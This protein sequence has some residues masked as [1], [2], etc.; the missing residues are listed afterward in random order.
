MEKPV[1]LKGWMP[2]MNA[3]WRHIGK[4]ITKSLMLKRVFFPLRSPSLKMENLPDRPKSA[5]KDRESRAVIEAGFI[6]FTNRLLRV[7]I[8]TPPM[9][10]LKA[11]PAA[12]RSPTPYTE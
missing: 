9:E 2:T 8:P 11:V 10:A 6:V 1:S 5:M 4:E 7:A 3:V 12:W